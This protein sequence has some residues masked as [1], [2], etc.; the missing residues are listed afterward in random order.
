M[1]HIAEAIKK[2]DES[3]EP[4][5]RTGKPSKKEIQDIVAGTGAAWGMADFI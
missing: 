5:D 1:D 4:E 2:V 3:R